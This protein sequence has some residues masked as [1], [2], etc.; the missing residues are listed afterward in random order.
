MEPRTVASQ[1][2]QRYRYTL[3][4]PPDGQGGKRT[5]EGIAATRGNIRRMRADGQGYSIGYDV[6]GYTRSPDAVLH[7]SLPTERKRRISRNELLMQ[8][9]EKVDSFSFWNRERP[10]RI[11]RS[12]RA[13]QLSLTTKKTLF[14]QN[15]ERSIASLMSANS[16]R[17]KM[18]IEK[19]IKDKFA[20]K[21]ARK[22]ASKMRY[23][24][25][26]IK[27]TGAEHKIRCCSGSNKNPASMLH[28]LKVE[29]NLMLQLRNKLHRKLMY[30]P[31]LDMFPGT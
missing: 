21:L 19:K 25:I 18:H 10:L 5:G 13:K 16:T 11:Q 3:W 22:L 4:P 17:I 23:S 30:V 2:R 29:E 7:I 9:P 14:Y 15:R 24:Q 12:Y 6:R 28:K 31:N 26:P 27:Q 20:L 1:W 8:S